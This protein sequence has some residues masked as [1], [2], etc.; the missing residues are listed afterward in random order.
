MKMRKL[1]Y[2]FLGAALLCI[3]AIIFIAEGM[4]FVFNFGINHH[5]YHIFWVVLS[6]FMGVFV[7]RNCVKK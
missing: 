3:L 6:F 1:S 7:C 4:N 5:L 2:E